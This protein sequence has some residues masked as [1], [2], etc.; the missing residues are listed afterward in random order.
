MTGEEETFLPPS[1]TGALE[2]GVRYE[3]SPDGHVR[4]VYVTE[5]RRHGETWEALSVE[6]A[7]RNRHLF[8]LPYFFEADVKWTGPHTF[9]MFAGLAYKAGSVRVD[10]DVDADGGKGRCVI[11]ETGQSVRFRDAE[12]LIERAYERHAT[13]PEPW[14]DQPPPGVEYE[15][16]RHSTP[17]RPATSLKDWILGLLGAAAI[18]A[19]LAAGVYM[20]NEMRPK[21]EPD[22]PRYPPAPKMK[23]VA[24]PKPEPSE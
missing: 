9:V 18:I 1:E 7:A 4:I 16:P 11:A 12:R 10:V 17:S 15:P 2:S 19:G 6:L 20:W 24:A 13:Y 14:P 21:G 22:E 23:T 3:L 8:A 5:E